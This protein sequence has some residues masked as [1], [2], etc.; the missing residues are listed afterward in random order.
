MLGKPLLGRFIRRR[1]MGNDRQSRA[2]GVRVDN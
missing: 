1:G 2:E